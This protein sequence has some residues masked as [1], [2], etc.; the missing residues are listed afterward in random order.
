LAS[1]RASNGTAKN[2]QLTALFYKVDPD[3]GLR[4]AKGLGLDGDEVK[5][6]AAMSQEE[7]VKATLK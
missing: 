7:R 5:R 1:S 4:V 3:Y 6:L 2:G